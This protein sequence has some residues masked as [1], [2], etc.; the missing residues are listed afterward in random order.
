MLEERGGL[1]ELACPF[2]CRCDTSMACMMPRMSATSTPLLEKELGQPFFDVTNT[3]TSSEAQE[4]QVPTQGPAC[5]LTTRF[6]SG[7]HC[8]TDGAFGP[9]HLKYGTVYA[10]VC[11]FETWV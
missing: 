8:A 2:C 9:C 3:S 6:R 1:G 10:E 7:L 4:A 5:R 11:V